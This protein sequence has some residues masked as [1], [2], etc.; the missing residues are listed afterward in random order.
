MTLSECLVM[1]P[2]IV[3]CFLQISEYFKRQNLLSVW[4]CATLV[5]QC[6]SLEER[7]AGMQAHGIRDFR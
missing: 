1:N 5:M 2:S 3:Q 7:P 4:K 6:V